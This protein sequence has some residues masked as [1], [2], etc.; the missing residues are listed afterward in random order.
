MVE[1][2]LYASTA[3]RIVSSLMQNGLV[4]NDQGNLYRLGLNLVHWGPLARQA[5]PACYRPARN[6]TSARQ[7]W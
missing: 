4:G 2:D 1:I 7:F 6:E 3:H 5:G